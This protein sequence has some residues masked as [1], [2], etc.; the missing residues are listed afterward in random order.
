M[1]CGGCGSYS[2]SPIS[3]GAVVSTSPARLALADLP[4]AAPALAGALAEVGERLVDRQVARDVEHLGGGLM[5]DSLLHDR[6]S[7]FYRR[8]PH[9]GLSLVKTPD[10]WATHR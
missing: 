1:S 4:P 5:K 10:F 8:P 6:H 3:E 2:H 9:Q 7:R